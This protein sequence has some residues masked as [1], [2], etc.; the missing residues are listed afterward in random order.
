MMFFKPL[1]KVYWYGYSRLQ[2]MFVLNLLIVILI[3]PL[4]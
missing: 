2:T 4:C 3:L 1:M